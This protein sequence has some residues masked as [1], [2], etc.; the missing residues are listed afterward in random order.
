M[1]MVQAVVYMVE[2][3][4]CHLCNIYY[5]Q[6]HVYYCCSQFSR[7]TRKQLCKSNTENLAD[8]DM[9]DF[10]MKLLQ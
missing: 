4:L 5:I 9:I 3:K 2:W 1:L 7:H 6:Q 10:G 8:H